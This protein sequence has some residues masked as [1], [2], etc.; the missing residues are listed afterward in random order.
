MWVSCGRVALSR[1]TS[2]A[3]RARPGLQAPQQR[4]CRSRRTRSAPTAPARASAVDHAAGDRAAVVVG[5]LRRGEHQLAAL[6]QPLAAFEPARALVARASPGSS[7]AR[8]ARAPRGSTS[9]TLSWPTSPIQTSLRPG[10]K[11]KRHGLRR[12]LSSTR[13]RARPPRVDVGRHELAQ[14]RAR[15]AGALPLGSKAPPA[16]AQPQVQP[17]VGAERQLAAVVV[18]LG[19]VERQQQPAARARRR[20]ELGHPRVARGGCSSARSTRAVAREVRVEGQAEHALLGALLHLVTQVEHG[21]PATVGAEPHD[22]ARL[23]EHVQRAAVAGRGAHPGRAHETRGHP[24]DGEV[25]RPRR[26]RARQ[27]AGADG[28]RHRRRSRA[29]SSASSENVTERAAGQGARNLIRVA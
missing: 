10:S 19:L 21:R 18:L 20:V 27:P 8:R 17:A 22:P 6:V 13:Q 5:V 9:S 7:A 28:A 26:T 11:E 14:Q 16:V 12:P 4:R 2:R 29:R 3:P 25:S 23:L 1:R 24:L 15:G